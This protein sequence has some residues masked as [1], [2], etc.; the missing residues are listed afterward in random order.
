MHRIRDPYRIRFQIKAA[1]A[2]RDGSCV[3]AFSIFFPRRNVLYI[4]FHGI[5][6]KSVIQT[7]G[8]DRNASQTALTEAQCIFRTVI[9]LV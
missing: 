8:D 1:T 6:L 2:R 5:L 3:A 9:L 7:E 4:S